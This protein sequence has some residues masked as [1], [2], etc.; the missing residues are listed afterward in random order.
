MYVYVYKYKYLYFT[1]QLYE[2]FLGSRNYISLHAAL[3]I[4]LFAKR[5]NLIQSKTRTAIV[6]SSFIKC[7]H[8][9]RGESH[10]RK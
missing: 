3:A 10:A 6:Q 4:L 8:G 2:T 5:L 7:G 1:T 9:S